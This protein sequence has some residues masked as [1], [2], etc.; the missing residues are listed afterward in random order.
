MIDILE[1]AYSYFGYNLFL[2]TNVGADKQIPETEQ[3]DENR[4]R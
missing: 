2:Q 1:I 3:Q 4:V